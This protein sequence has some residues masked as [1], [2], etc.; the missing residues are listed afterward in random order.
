MLKEPYKPEFEEFIKLKILALESNPDISKIAAQTLTS[1]V[2]L[3]SSILN[4]DMK[5]FVKKNSKETTE[6]LCQFIKEEITKD[7]AEG[8]FN[9]VIKASEELFDENF[10]QEGLEILPYFLEINIEHINEKLFKPIFYLLSTKFT[11]K[12]EFG[13]LNRMSVDIGIDI[14]KRNAEKYGEQLLLVL[15]SFINKASGVSNII[16]LGVL[17]RYL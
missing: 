12:E 11:S 16:F 17:A 9:L 1:E 10:D 13:T 15:E 4:F 2:E 6:K 3:K 8:I 5:T 14:I 7:N